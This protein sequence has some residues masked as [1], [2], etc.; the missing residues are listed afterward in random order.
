MT[1]AEDLCLSRKD[2]LALFRFL[3]HDELAEIAC[4]F[5]LI[6]AEAKEVLWREGQPCEFLGF[7]ARGRIEIKKDTEFAGKGGVV[8]GVYG[9]GTVIGELCV[10]DDSPREVTAVALDDVEIVALRRE[11]FDTLLETQPQLAVKLLRGMLLACSR[12]LRK[13]LD[14]LVAVF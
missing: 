6:R 10:L 8:L 13:S 7:I 12:R 2:Q 14:R 5:D 9:E 11:R 3:E 4:G 1:T